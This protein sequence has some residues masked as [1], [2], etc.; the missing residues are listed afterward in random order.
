MSIIDKIK[1]DAV[2]TD[3]LTGEIILTIFDHLDWENVQF[4]LESL[5]DK[6]NS[7]IEFIEGKQ[8][9]EDYPDSKDGRLVI[10]IVS[11][12]EY[13]TEGLDYLKKVKPIIQSIG[14]DVRQRL[15]KD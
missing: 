11:K 14:A 13:S 8:V 12:Y 5:Q 7:Y 2:G 6:L 3:K 9:F 4:H 15:H 10:E 1:I